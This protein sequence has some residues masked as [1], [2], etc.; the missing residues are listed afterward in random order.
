LDTIEQRLTYRKWYCGHYHTDKSIDCLQ[1]MFHDFDYLHLNGEDS[2][3][4]ARPMSA[5][6][7]NFY[8]S[9]LHLGH[10]NIIKI[11]NRPFTDANEMNETLIKYWNA[12]VRPCDHVYVVG[13]LAFRSPQS[14]KEYIERLQG[15]KHLILG[16]HDR[17]WVKQVRLTDY[18]ESIE[19]LQLIKDGNC[20]VVLC[21]YPMMSWGGGKN[22]YLVYGHIHN[23]KNSSYWPLLRT[24]DRALNASV[25]VNDYQPVILDELIANN[26]VFRQGER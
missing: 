10:A 12:R 9:D 23:N 21:H 3:V 4:R 15:I 17:S 26:E 6:P 7:L 22:S 13:D 19:Q 8:T 18:F 2:I 16:N 24:Y 20:R 5:S 14:V 11:C 25:E 1:F